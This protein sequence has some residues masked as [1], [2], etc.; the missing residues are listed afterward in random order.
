M[1]YPIEPPT[2]LTESESATAVARSASGTT[3]IATVA[4]G[5]RIPPTPIPAKEPIVTVAP[6]LNGVATAIA[7]SNAAVQKQRISNLVR[8]PHHHTRVAYS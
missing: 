8:K 6:T 4:A 5:T 3:I 2:V 7:P 1:V